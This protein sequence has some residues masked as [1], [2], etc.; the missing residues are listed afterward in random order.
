[1]LKPTYQM[2]RMLKIRQRMSH[3]NPQQVFDNKCH[4]KMTM[5][6]VSKA[7]KASEKTSNV[8]AI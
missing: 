8:F 5:D 6:R 7:T 4:D 3:N 1:M 2:M